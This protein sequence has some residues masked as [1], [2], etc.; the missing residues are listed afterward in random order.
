MRTMR[1]ISGIILLTLSL[2]CIADTVRE[3]AQGKYGMGARRFWAAMVF[4][5]GCGLAGLAL[6]SGARGG[7]GM[8]G[9]GET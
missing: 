7:K 2:I 6:L 8:A 9:G 4:H 5:P 3:M 1:L